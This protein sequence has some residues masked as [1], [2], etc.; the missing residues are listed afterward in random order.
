MYLLFDAES[1]FLR[2]NSMEGT[3]RSVFDF[4][5]AS[6]Y[7]LGFVTGNG[8]GFRAT[9]FEYD[10]L[11]NDVGGVGQVAFDTYNMDFEIFKR[12]QLTTS[13]KFEIG[14]GMRYNET[15]YFRNGPTNFSNFRGIGVVLG[16]KG[17]TTVFTGGAIYG[18][19]RGSILSGEGSHEGNSFNGRHLKN[20]GR[21]QFE[22]GFGYEHPVQVGVLEFTPRLGAEMQHFGGYGI[23]PVDEQ[24]DADLYLAGFLVG[25]DVRF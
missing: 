1:L 16:V 17:S 5:T 15:N 2:F 18:R 23:D 13:T 3:R 24:P 25:M 10:D 21:S 9:Y 12:L 7:S 22:L 8:L 11:A 19:A 14:G 20:I 4:E 6:R